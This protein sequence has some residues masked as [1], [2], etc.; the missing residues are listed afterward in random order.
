[1]SARN[2][3]LSY[4]RGIN[5]LKDGSWIVNQTQRLC[6]HAIC[7]HRIGS[8]FI[9]ISP[10]KLTALA[11]M[12]QMIF[13]RSIDKGNMTV[14]TC[15]LPMLQVS[16]PSSP[17]PKHSFAILIGQQYPTSDRS[18]IPAF[19]KPEWYKASWANW[20]PLYAQP[21]YQLWMCRRSHE[22]AGH[23]APRYLGITPL[24]KNGVLLRCLKC[25]SNIWC[26]HLL[27]KW[28]VL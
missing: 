3:A 10:K 5:K 17:T 25:P 4:S 28:A 26:V 27:S 1:M 14:S 18:G 2:L 19:A 15:Y 8:R 24:R 6:V 11:K 16:N 20:P 7:A 13:G 9:V 21:S 22:P 12:M 23:P